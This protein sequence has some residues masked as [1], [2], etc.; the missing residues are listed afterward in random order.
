MAD[1]IAEPLR[2]LL[3]DVTLGRYPAPDGSV[4]VRRNQLTG[5][6]ACSGSPPTR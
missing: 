1:L 5:A 4:T 3:D 2:A 6:L